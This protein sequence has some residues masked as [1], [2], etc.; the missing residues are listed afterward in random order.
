MIIPSRDDLGQVGADIPR[1]IDRSFSL[2]IIV[3]ELARVFDSPSARSKKTRVVGEEGGISVLLAI[4]Q[5]SEVL[6]LSRWRATQQDRAADAALRQNFIYKALIAPI[7]SSA[8]RPP[9]PA[10]SSSYE[11]P[12]GV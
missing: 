10:P 5:V 11:C 6:G 4:Y 8:C 7:T 2:A 9:P 1:E 12:G 3:P